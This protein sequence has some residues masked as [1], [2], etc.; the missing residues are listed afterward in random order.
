MILTEACKALFIFM[1]IKLTVGRDFGSRAI[2]LCVGRVLCVK[3][4]LLTNVGS[5]SKQLVSLIV[6]YIL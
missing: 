3:L 2:R 6:K 5:V 4:E 1:I